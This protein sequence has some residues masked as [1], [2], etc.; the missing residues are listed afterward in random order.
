MDA[1]PR[2]CAFCGAPADDDH[3]LD[4]CDV[5]GR[6][7]DDLLRGPKCHDDHELLHE[8]LRR[9]QIDKPL[10]STNILDQLE[11][12]LRRVAVYVGRAA[13]ATGFQW[14]LALAGSCARWAE[15]LHAAIVALD[16]RD[17]AWR[18]IV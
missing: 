3:H 13:E 18:W 17:P 14:C 9:Q 16:A 6:H 12:F 5:A 8:D 11:R 7:L 15:R 1:E 10:Q 4:G 2:L